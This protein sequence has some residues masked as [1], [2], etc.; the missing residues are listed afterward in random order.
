MYLLGITK[1]DFKIPE[2][3]RN[4]LSFGS[5]LNIQKPKKSVLK[6]YTRI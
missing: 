6:V 4:I 1:S 2:R 5:E 3:E